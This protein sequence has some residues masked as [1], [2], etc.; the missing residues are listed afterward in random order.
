MSHP[1]PLTTTW[2]TLDRHTA[3]VAVDGDLD[4]DTADR[5]LREVVDRLP[6][7]R[8]L[9]VDLSALGFCDSYGLSVLLMVRRHVDASSA[10]LHLDNRPTSLERLLT[11]TNTLQHL[12]GDRVVAH[13]Q[14]PEP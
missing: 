1:R 11:V 13:Q 7:L 9:H 8:D 6:Q 3:R 14:T 2:T 10:V 5:L 12:T 4:Y